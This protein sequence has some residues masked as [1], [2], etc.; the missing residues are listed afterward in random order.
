[1]SIPDSLMERYFYLASTYSVDDA[2]K[3][4]A[5]VAAGS[6]E[7]MAAKRMLARNIAAAYHSEEEAV[8]AEAEFD[9][10]HRDRQAPEEM[11]EVHLGVQP[12]EDGTL[13]LPAVLQ[14]LGF[15]KS[16]GEARRLIDGGGVKLAG[17]AVAAKCYNVAP[18][19][20]AAGTVVQVGRRHFARL[21]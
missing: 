12:G 15:A 6:L 4:L 11:D 5:A 21:V 19:A 3:I 8:A 17:E 13:Y 1:M 9:R 18:E 16:A 20:C 14:E 2:D 10:V 7:P